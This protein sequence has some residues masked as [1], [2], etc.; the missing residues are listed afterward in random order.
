MK[1]K[2]SN[3]TSSNG[4]EAPN[5]FIIHTEEGMYFQSYNS[6]IVFRPRKGKVQLGKD[7]DYSTTTGKYR[8]MFLSESK[9]ETQAKLDSGEYILNENL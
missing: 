8:N 7:W 6:I 4:N 1:V 5:Q 9:K 3:M 2:V